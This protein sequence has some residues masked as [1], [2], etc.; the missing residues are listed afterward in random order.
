MSVAQAKADV[1]ATGKSVVKAGEQLA[2]AKGQL[3]RLLGLAANHTNRTA[4]A[5]MHYNGT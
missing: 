3:S 2:R 1:K 5:K 4:L